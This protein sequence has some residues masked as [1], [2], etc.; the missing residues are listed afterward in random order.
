MSSDLKRIDARGFSFDPELR[1]RLPAFAGTPATLTLSLQ[2][3]W[4]SGPLMRY[5]YQVDPA[6]AT[7]D[8]PAYTARAGYLGTDVGATLNRRVR[9]GLSW[10]VTGIVTSLHGAA[11]AGSPLL[12][13]RSNVSLGAGVIWTPWHSGAVVSDHAP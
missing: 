4:A 2:P 3:S 12:R 9:P 6:Q 8:R 13:S 1:W 10:F 7:A 11:N 5:F